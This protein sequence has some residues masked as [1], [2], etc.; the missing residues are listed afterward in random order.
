HPPF[1]LLLC[2]VPLNPKTR[3]KVLHVS[4][5]ITVRLLRLLA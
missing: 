4:I 1:L 2:C 5:A 3:T